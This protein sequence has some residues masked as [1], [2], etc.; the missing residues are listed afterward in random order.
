MSWKATSNLF[1]WI[2]EHPELEFLLISL[3]WNRGRRGGIHGEIS[4]H[5][6]A[7]KPIT[8]IS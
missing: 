1:G 4:G 3:D 6:P 8:V 2:C 7:A 5:K